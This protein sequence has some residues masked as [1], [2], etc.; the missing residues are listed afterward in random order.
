MGC[1]SG[2]PGR[3]SAAQKRALVEFGIWMMAD[4]LSRMATAGVEGV[5]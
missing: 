3:E 2:T 1:P 5:T 4:C